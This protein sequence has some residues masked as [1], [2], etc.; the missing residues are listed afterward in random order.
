ML[1]RCISHTSHSL[2]GSESV[3]RLTTWLKV[4]GDPQTYSRVCLLRNEDGTFWGFFVTVFMIR[5]VVL[6]ASA[7]SL[8][9]CYDI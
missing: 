5:L 3:Q 9:V 4:E 2:T 1:L 8:E 6:P 7:V